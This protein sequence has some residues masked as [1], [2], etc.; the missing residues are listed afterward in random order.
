VGRRA[1]TLNT[2]GKSLSLRPEKI[3]AMKKISFVALTI[4][5]ALAACKNKPGDADASAISGTD[6]EEPALEI[7]DSVKHA[8]KMEEKHREA[9]ANLI[10]E[11][12]FEQKGQAGSFLLTKME[13]TS[14]EKIDNLAVAV[15]QFIQGKNIGISLDNGHYGY[16]LIDLNGDGINDA[17]VLLTGSNFCEN[18]DCTLLIAKG[19]AGGKYTVHSMIEFIGAPI[20][21]SES[22]TKGWRDI[23]TQVFDE[24]G[25]GTTMQL[26][27]D[28][29]KY[30]DGP[31]AAGAKPLATPVKV[32]GYLMNAGNSGL[33]LTY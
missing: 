7:F 15:R 2:A 13:D 21:V 33:N 11:E 23:V 4:L 10:S 20:L 16:N 28:G 29:R 22:S 31:R 5:L 18:T 6:P 30:P 32:T 19:E 24:K 17:L 27:F 26:A 12:N 1:Q 3:I 14:Y 9:E 8:A 25:T